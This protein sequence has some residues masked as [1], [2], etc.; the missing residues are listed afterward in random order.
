M[1]EHILIVDDERELAELVS[2]YLTN[3]GFRTSVCPDGASALAL[4][5]RET[6]DLA[7]L[8][9]MLP[10]MSGFDICR[11]IRKTHFFPIIMLTA[12]IEDNDKILGLTLGADDYITKPFN[13][14]EVVARVRTQL[15]RASTYNHAAAPESAEEIDIRG[16]V[17][18]RAAHSCSL[19]GEQIALTPL[20][21]E[22]LWY[23]ASM[24]ATSPPK[25]QMTASP[26]PSLCRLECEKIVR[27]LHENRKDFA[28]P[29]SNT[30]R[31]HFVQWTYK[32]KAFLFGG[33]LVL[34]LNLVS[35]Y[36]LSCALL[37]CICV[38]IWRR[39]MAPLGHRAWALVFCLYLWTV[40]T[41]TGA[42][43][44]TDIFLQLRIFEELGIH[45]FSDLYAALH[46]PLE[47]T[48]FRVRVSLVP[49]QNLTSGFLLNILMTMPLGFLLPFLYRDWRRFSRAVLAGAGFSLLIE[50]SQLLTNRACDIDDLIAN[51]L[52]AALGYALWWYMAQIFGTR[53]QKTPSDRRE[54]LRLILA[55]FGGMFFLY[56]PF[57]FYSLIGY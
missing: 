52:G 40:Y 45:S 48:V 4:V 47:A 21:F 30:E 37:P 25:A 33:G 18:N 2:L 26:S 20:E 31:F 39:K 55:S 43:G 41:V 50:C 49:F 23:L 32:A 10:D 6:P 44:L 38:L 7:L 57:W 17:I 24:A 27:N 51:A 13:P 11:E 12:K 5:R 34:N 14:L 36:S 19:Y 15:R 29:P 53:L 1:N 46:D 28:S 42:G 3:A 54:P 9:V 56:H 22:I 16:L 8:D 35:F